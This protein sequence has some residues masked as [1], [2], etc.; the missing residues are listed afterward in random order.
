[1]HVLL[2][3]DGK[4]P[5][6]L[7]SFLNCLVNVIGSLFINIV[8]TPLVIVPLIPMALVYDLIRRRYTRIL[9]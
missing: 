6:S 8:V 9:N 3:V 5:Q 7:G 4:V 2:A 1:M